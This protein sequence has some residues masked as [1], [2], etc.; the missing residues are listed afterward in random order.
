MT[1]WGIRQSWGELTIGNGG[2][3][4]IKNGGQLAVENGA[5]IA[6]NG[7]DAGNPR[8]NGEPRGL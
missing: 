8:G 3:L 1:E 5:A 7:G 6:V 4:T 2:T